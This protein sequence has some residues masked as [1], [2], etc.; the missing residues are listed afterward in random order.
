[1]KPGDVIL[2]ALPQFDGRIKTRPAVV[3]CLV[4]PHRDP[5]I[6]GI[7]TQLHEEVRGLDDLIIPSDA[8]FAGSG[9]K[10]SS[11]IHAAFLTVIIPQRITGRIG[12]ISAVRLQRLLTRLGQHMLDHAAR[13]P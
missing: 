3:L 5:L 2:T 9:L 7:S 8:D 6:C 10:A 13:L 4:E 1:M 11:L 12:T